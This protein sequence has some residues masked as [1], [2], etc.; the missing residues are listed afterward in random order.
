MTTYA[1]RKIAEA[2][3]ALNQV[4]EDPAAFVEWIRAK[5]H[6]DYLQANAKSE[7][8]IV[9]TS[10]PFSFIHS[11]V[12]PSDALAAEDP[13]ALLHWSANPFTSIASYVSGGGRDL[14]GIHWRPERGAYCRF[15]CN[16]G[17]A[18]LVSSTPRNTR[19]D[20]SLVTL[21]L[22]RSAA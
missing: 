16:G 14:S 12:V 9:Y 17:L 22:S 2:I 15:D 1:H 3:A 8:L 6:L 7:E 18:D 10:G 5:R 11:I 21:T 19:D 4:P 20:V 13:E